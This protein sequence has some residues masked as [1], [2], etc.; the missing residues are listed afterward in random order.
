MGL[1]LTKYYSIVEK[2]E[3]NGEEMFIDSQSHTPYGTS[4]LLPIFNN[5]NAQTSI[6]NEEYGKQGITE[7]EIV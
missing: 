7:L 4:R 3:E 1:N 2:L 5:L 6:S